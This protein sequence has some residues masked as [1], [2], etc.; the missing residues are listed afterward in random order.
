MVRGWI[1]RDFG[2]QL[3]CTLNVNFQVFRQQSNSGLFFLR[4]FVILLLGRL[5]DRFCMDVLIP[6]DVKSMQNHARVIR[7]EYFTKIREVCFLMRLV[8][9]SWRHLGRPGVTFPAS[10]S[11]F[12]ENVHIKSIYFISFR[13]RFF[14]MAF[15]GG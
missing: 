8:C 15:E 10:G 9:N 5:F 12:E 2:A 4:T 13:R 3:D 14:G 7:N 6:G 1:Y 11:I